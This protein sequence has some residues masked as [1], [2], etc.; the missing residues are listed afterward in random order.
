MEKFHNTNIRLSREE[1]EETLNIL[2]ASWK[3]LTLGRLDPNFDK[4]DSDSLSERFQHTLNF[5]RCVSEGREVDLDQSSNV[6][7][8]SH[9]GSVTNE[10]IQIRLTEEGQTNIVRSI[11]ANDFQLHIECYRTIVLSYRFLLIILKLFF[12]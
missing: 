11:H 10:V 9:C 5:E 6:S 7:S 4:F 8:P 2:K 12:P 1:T 3:S